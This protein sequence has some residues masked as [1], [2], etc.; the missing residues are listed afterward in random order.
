MEFEARLKPEYRRKHPDLNPQRWY[1]VV[2]LW[3]GVTQRTQNMSGQRLARLKTAH[4]FTMVLAEHLEFRTRKSG[5][6]EAAG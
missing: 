5:E 1:P 4:D 2:P 3:P 6:T